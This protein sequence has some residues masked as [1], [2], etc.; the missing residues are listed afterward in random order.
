[1]S[2]DSPIYSQRIKEERQLLNLSMKELSD[3]TLIPYNSI[4]N[5]EKGLRKITQTNAEKLADFF[6]VSV[7]YIMGLSETRNELSSE[8]IEDIAK[9]VDNIP[10]NFRIKNA[11]LEII[12]NFQS[13]IKNSKNLHVRYFLKLIDNKNNSFVFTVLHGI[14][15]T[16]QIEYNFYKEETEIT[17]LSQF[18]I[19]DRYEAI[20]DIVNYKSAIS[21]KEKIFKDEF[22]DQ[23]IFRGLLREEKENNCFKK[24]Y[25]DICGYTLSLEDCFLNDLQIKEANMT[26]KF[27]VNSLNEEFLTIK[28]PYKK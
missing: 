6:Q 21:N 7:P 14:F 13:N 22:F 23:Y 25:E 12:G 2:E 3:E 1:M 4:R 16:E 28:I 19:P 20:N 26:N 11:E 18:L 8:D 17:V 24:A 9:V 15:L 5:Y 10:E 27:R